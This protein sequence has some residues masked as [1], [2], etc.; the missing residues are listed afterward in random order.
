MSVL[1]Y[2]GKL[3]GG[4]EEAID[5]LQSNLSEQ[6]FSIV[7]RIDMHTTLKEKINVDFRKFSILGVCNA[8]LAHQ[9]LESDPEAG[10]LL[11]CS[12]TVE[13]L[14]EGDIQISI[15]KPTVMLSLGEIGKNEKIAELALDADKR[16]TLV[17]NKLFA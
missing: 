4:F 9:V 12:V 5:R 7:S 6:G 11:P 8:L 13:E 1:S 16:L 10:L 14:S 17:A 3:N 2:Q 15:I